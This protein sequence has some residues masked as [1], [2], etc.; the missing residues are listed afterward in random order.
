MGTIQVLIQKAPEFEDLLLNPNDRVGRNA[1]WTLFHTHP[2]EGFEYDMIASIRIDEITISPE[3]E[4]I[5]SFVE[6]KEVERWEDV[7]D[8]DGN[9][10]TDSLGNAIQV[11]HIDKFTAYITEVNRSKRAQFVAGME[12]IDFHSGNVMIRDHFVHDIEFNSGA[13]SF[14]GDLEALPIGI[15]KRIDDTLL[16]FPSDHLMLIEAVEKFDRRF[17]KALNKVNFRNAYDDLALL[18]D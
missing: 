7:L 14:Q 10:V 2:V 5:N 16:P 3:Q 11:K 17:I 9:L 6:R 1:K 13:C 8:R 4:S 15:R 18:S 12:V